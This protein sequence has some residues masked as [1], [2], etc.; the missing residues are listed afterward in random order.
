ML[1]KPLQDVTLADLRSL[2]AN[3]A[4]ESITLDFKQELPGTSDADKKDFLADV[5]AFANANGGTFVFGISETTSEDGEAG[6]AEELVGLDQVSRDEERRRLTE[7]LRSGI[8]PRLH[9][10]AIEFLGGEEEPLAMLLE[11]ERSWN[12]PH[13]VSYKKPQTSFPVRHGPQKAWMDVTE[14][15][16]AFLR[17][18]AAVERIR[19]FRQARVQEVSNR[20]TPT[21]IDRQPAALVH[22][23]PILSFDQTDALD[24]KAAFEALKSRPPY[25]L[26]GNLGDLL[27]NLDGVLRAYLEDGKAT[28]YLQLFR[29]GSIESLC[30]GRPF[31]AERE[32][33]GMFFPTNFDI[34]V[35]EFTSAAISFLADQDVPPPYSL[36][37]SLLNAHSYT[38]YL[39]ERDHFHRSR[40]GSLTTNYALLPDLLLETTD[41]AD[42][43]Q[44]LRPLLDVAWQAFGFERCFSYDQDGTWTPRP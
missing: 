6:L 20:R 5:C 31:F 29:D 10:F 9:R 39:S 19:Q 22:L 1:G 42:L 8:Q 11:V 14:L 24:P 21:P 43:P 37:V 7:M 12:A 16:D 27:Y 18:D 23:V 17:S 35:F 13:R 30:L 15:R 33:Q 26:G 41:P 32:G 2:C 3:K 4:P 36:A 38:P 44:A 34:Q 40:T 25:C 28:A